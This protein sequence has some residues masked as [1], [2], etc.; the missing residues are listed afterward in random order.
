MPLLIPLIF[1]TNSV[2]SFAGGANLP[3]ASVTTDRDIYI[4]G[5]RLYFSMYL[6]EY[7]TP[8]EDGRLACIVL[9]CRSNKTITSGIARLDMGRAW[10]SLY[11]EDT[12]ST[13][14]YQIACY[15]AMTGGA[16][17]R[18][19]AGRQVIVVNRF[20]AEL[21]ELE[22]ASGQGTA[23]RQVLTVN[24]SDSELQGTGLTTG[25]E[26]SGPDQENGGY[27]LPGESVVSISTNR[28]E[29][30]TREMVIA[31]IEPAAGEEYPLWASITV[32]RAETI[33]NSGYSKQYGRHQIN[34][35][36]G[37]TV[38][39]NEGNSRRSGLEIRGKVTC[40]HEGKPLEGID[41]FLTSAGNIIDLHHSI[42]DTGG[43]FSFTL[44][45]YH[46]LEEVYISPRTS[47]LSAG[48][49][50]ETDD[51][52][53]VAD[54]FIPE[55]VNM[56]Q[57]LIS[58]IRKSQDITSVNKLFGISFHYE[59]SEPPLWDHRRPMLYSA[60]ANT[61]IPANFLP[62]DDL[63]EISRELVPQW[64]IRE[65]DGVL[66][67]R[68]VNSRTRQYFEDPPAVFLNGV[69]VV[70]LIDIRHLRSG[71]IEKIEV[72]NYPWR[73][74]EI[75]FSGI[76]SITGTGN[77]Y[78]DM[79][80]NGTYSVSEIPA[81]IPRSTIDPPVYDG[82]GNNDDP[83]FRHTLYWEPVIA[84]GSIDEYRAFS[85]YTGDLTGP[86]IIRVKGVTS[87]GTRF[88]EQKIF[89]VR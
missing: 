28:N 58:A 87:S 15:G 6:P 75:E 88:T 62:L 67:S 53:A 33:T 54:G 26:T 70:N 44:N 81:L 21:Q 79:V 83:D 18:N 46:D 89:I 73:Y 60:P 77:E 68:L 4:A 24:R 16:G 17:G 9:R 1:A 61:V 80:T 40:I 43:K 20:D 82:S 51:R 12:I 13:G 64:Q 48:I 32:A 2:F 38:A 35:D 59:P 22:L 27:V 85:F 76:V 66:F 29:Y 3:P 42:T 72:H 36:P 30:G 31:G 14:I 69:H 8:G 47:P 52:F 63:T 25:H 86:F 55:R 5:E 65:R 37:S 10:G 84:S 34:P 49:K 50:I 23:G 45:N 57:A 39:A 71:D 11:L 41:M 19:T 56:D 74:G 7:D 78:R